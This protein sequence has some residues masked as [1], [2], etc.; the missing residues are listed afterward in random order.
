MEKGRHGVGR[1]L[2]NVWCTA[3]TQTLAAISGQSI[4]VP[5]ACFCPAQADGFP[6]SLSYAAGLC[7]HLQSSRKSQDLGRARLDLE[8]QCRCMILMFNPLANQI[9]RRKKLCVKKLS[10]QLRSHRSYNQ[11]QAA[12]LQIPQVPTTPVSVSLHQ[13]SRLETVQSQPRSPAH[14]LSAEPYI[15]RGLCA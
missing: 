15:V 5:D 1:V 4:I 14:K 11:T 2:G 7:P 6:S 10:N 12:F 3:S 9:S 13:R 8:R